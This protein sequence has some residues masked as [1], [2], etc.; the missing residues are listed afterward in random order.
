MP[1]YIYEC[2]DCLA[3]VDKSLPEDQ[4]IEQTLFETSHSMNPSK[5]EFIEAT[6]CPRCSSN[7]CRQSF[8]DYNVTSFVRG[9]GWLDKVGTRRDM[10]LY[11]L[12]NND[13]YAQYRQA[14]EVDNIK[15][16]IKKKGRFDPK[17]KYFPVSIK[18][19]QKEQSILKK[20]VEKSVRDKT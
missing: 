15:N 4:I 9:Y 2:I 19:Q 20:A 17:T 11:H 8:Y 16:D 12:N 3:K 7:N 14:G 6:I 10:D 5:K 18:E 13:P 1:R